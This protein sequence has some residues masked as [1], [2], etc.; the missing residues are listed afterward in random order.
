M[1]ESLQVPRI[2]VDCDK[3]QVVG[4]YKAFEDEIAMIKGMKH[5]SPYHAEDVDTHIQMTI[6]GAKAQSESIHYT[7]DEIVTLAELHDLG[8]GITKKP[9]Q[10]RGSLM[11]I[12]WKLMVLIACSLIINTLELCMLLLNSKMI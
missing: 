3:I 11:I 10:S 12:L 4:D 7:K 5:D 2:G 9:S 1:Y 6:D 8:K